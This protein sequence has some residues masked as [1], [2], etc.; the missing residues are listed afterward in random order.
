[1]RHRLEHGG[2]P[3]AFFNPRKNAYCKMRDARN[4]RAV[5]NQE[6]ARAAE[7]ACQLRCMTRDS[8][9]L[10]SRT[11]GPYVS[12]ARAKRQQGSMRSHGWLKGRRRIPTLPVMDELATASSSVFAL[13]KFHHCGVS[14]A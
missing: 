2:A 8:T 7:L 3:R 12:T 1:M 9:P 6:V 10:G 5:T 4:A 14:P 11:S 13:G